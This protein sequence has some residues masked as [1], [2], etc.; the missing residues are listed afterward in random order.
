M[1]ETPAP[2]KAGTPGERALVL[3]PRRRWSSVRVPRPAPRADASAYAVA[4]ACRQFLED[5]WEGTS[6]VPGFAHGVARHRG[7]ASVMTAA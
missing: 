7:I 5:L 6:R 2:T 4:H 3:V 1:D